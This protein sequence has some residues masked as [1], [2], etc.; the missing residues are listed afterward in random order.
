[1]NKTDFRKTNRCCAILL[2]WVAFGCGAEE[3]GEDPTLIAS[4]EGAQ[5]MVYEDPYAPDM[6]GTPNPVR[7]AATAAAEA[8]EVDGSLRVLL[9]VRGFPADRTF[10]SHLHRLECDD[11][12]KA[13]GHYQHMPFPAGGMATDPDYANAMNEAWLD[14]TTDA[15]GRAESDLTMSWLPRSGEAKA[16]IIHDMA[17]GEGGVSG[18]KLACLPITG[19]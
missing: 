2:S 18:A 19:F 9:A 7:Q 6:A 3:E 11:P 17:T 8:Y 1:M 14:F 16:I 12:A 5:L 4:S 15:T 10:G 13:G